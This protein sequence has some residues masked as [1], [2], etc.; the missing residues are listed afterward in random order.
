MNK[1]QQPYSAKYYFLEQETRKNICLKK[2]KFDLQIS[3][4][5]CKFAV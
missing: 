3:V 4:Q 2:F 1:I 5:N